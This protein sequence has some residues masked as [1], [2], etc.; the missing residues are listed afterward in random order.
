MKRRVEVTRETNTGRNE[1]FRDV[2]TGRRMTRP[3][4]VRE[5]DNG[6][7]PDYHTSKIGDV[8]TLASNPDDS[9]NNNLG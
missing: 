6:K 8:R 4:F 2:N 5:I 1:E 7:Y 3:E 9:E